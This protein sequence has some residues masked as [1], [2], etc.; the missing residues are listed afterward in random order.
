M[1][2]DLDAF[3]TCVSSLLAAADRNTFR[4]AL[5]NPAFY[6]HV[7]GPHY[8]AMLEEA[9]RDCGARLNRCMEGREAQWVSAICLLSHRIC[10]N[11][12]SIG[13]VTFFRLAFPFMP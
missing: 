11:V 13:F 10:R 4:S 6:S 5:P 9:D 3:R 12:S 2:S 1:R 8:C 7:V